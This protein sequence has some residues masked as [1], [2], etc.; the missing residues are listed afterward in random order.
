MSFDV[1]TRNQIKVDF[2]S[3]ESVT[4][5]ANRYNISRKQ[6]Y[7]WIKDENW[8]RTVTAIDIIKE[9]H[10]REWDLHREIHGVPRDIESGRAAKLA[11]D[12]LETRHKNERIAY[13]ITDDK[14]PLTATIV[15][16]RENVGQKDN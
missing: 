15:I 5:I 3:G 10:R 8:I 13:D 7:K 1:Q 16:K 14:E 6:I 11:S 2:L 12:M 4:V 9:R